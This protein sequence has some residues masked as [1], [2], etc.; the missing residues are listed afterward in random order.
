[1]IKHYLLLILLLVGCSDGG[2]DSDSTPDDFAISLTFSRVTKIGLDDIKVSI[3]VTNNEVGVSGITPVVTL[4]AGTLSTMVESSNGVYD[5]IITPVSTGEFPISVSHGGVSKSGTAL[6]LN[7][8]HVGWG[9]PMSVEGLVNTEGYEDGPAVSVDGE[10]LFVQTGPI[11]F[12]GLV[13]FP[14]LAGCNSTLVGCEATTHGDWVYDVV[15]PYT[16]PERP[17]FYTKRIM[18]NKVS[19]FTD[20][21]GGLELFSP[22]TLFYGFKRQIDGSY[23]QP[24]RVSIDDN[25]EALLNPFGLYPRIDSATTMTIVFAFN[26]PTDELGDNGQDIYSAPLTL[27]QDND[28]M[29]FSTAAGMIRESTT[30][31]VLNLPSHLGTQGNPHLYSNGDGTVDSVW[32]D[33]EYNSDPALDLFYYQLTAGTFPSGTW[34][35]ATQLP[36]DKLDLPTSSESM[37]FFDGTTLYI[38]RDSGIVSSNY[39]GGGYSASSAWTKT[40]S[41]IDGGG[42]CTDIGCISV[43]GEPTIAKIDG[44]TYLFFVYALLRSYDGGAH[45]D[46]NMQIGFIEKTS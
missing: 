3:T 31:T 29:T 11:Y 4:A 9:Q 23:A 43:V 7:D 36:T 28:L 1:M 6:V 38:H 19:H 15:G 13:Y 16:T 25:Q 22:P 35:S 40:V 14:S 33:N 32:V 37:P 30:A 41:I 24:F 26:D 5:F 42:S 12:S 46:L 10:W 17:G 39:L 2:S 27:G 18:A 34:S 45:G 20:F 8:V 21:Y 44:K